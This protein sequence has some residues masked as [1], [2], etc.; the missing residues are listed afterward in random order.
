[1]VLQPLQGDGISSKSAF[2]KTSVMLLP[3]LWFRH[4]MAISRTMPSPSVARGITP[5]LAELP[6][7]WA[8]RIALGSLSIIF[9]A[10]QSISSCSLETS[11]MKTICYLSTKKIFFLSA[12]LRFRS[13]GAERAIAVQYRSWSYPLGISDVVLLRIVSVR[14]VFERNQTAAITETI[15]NIIPPP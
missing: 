9:C 15:T 11:I 1:M 6:S 12:R 8:T 4:R 7:P 2:T 5:G 3:P 13:V 14:Q 10:N